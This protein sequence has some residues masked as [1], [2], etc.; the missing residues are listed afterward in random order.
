MLVGFGRLG[1]RVN[2][3]GLLWVLGFVDVFVTIGFGV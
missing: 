3:L 2:S 1:T